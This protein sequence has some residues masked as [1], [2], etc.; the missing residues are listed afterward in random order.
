MA[1]E[2]SGGAGLLPEAG[3][4]R[5]QFLRLAA[6]AA[7]H[8]AGEAD[9]ARG[10]AA[11]ERIKELYH[12]ERDA[13][14]MS[15]DERKALRRERANPIL[16][17]FRK[18]LEAEQP[19]VLP[20]GPM[21][22]AIAYALSNW[23]ALERYTEVE[24]MGRKQRGGSANCLAT[25]LRGLKGKRRENDD[26]RNG[27][28]VAIQPLV[29]VYIWSGLRVCNV[30]L[31]PADHASEAYPPPSGGRRER[32]PSPWPLQRMFQLHPC[33]SPGRIPCESTAFAVRDQLLP[34]GCADALARQRIRQPHLRR[35]EKPPHRRPRLRDPHRA[36]AAVDKD[37]RRA[38][39][40]ELLDPLLH[41]GI[42]LAPQP[43]QLPD[44]LPR[45]HHHER[46]PARPA[47]CYVLK[48]DLAR[49]AAAKETVHARYK[50]LALVEWAFR[51]AKTVQLEMRPLYLRRAGQPHRREARALIDNPRDHPPQSELPLARGA[52]RGGYSQP[53]RDVIDDPDR[54]DRRPLPE[55]HRFGD[56]SELGEIVLVL[57]GQADGGDLLGRAVGQI[58]DRAV[59][60]LAAVAEGLAQDVARILAL[61]SAGIDVHSGYHTCGGARVTRIWPIPHK[62]SSGYPKG[63]NFAPITCPH[64]T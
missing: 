10:H 28:L 59:F 7:W 57:Q 43:G 13:K 15:P 49:K 62:H 3:R 29:K 60:D 64:T 51:T 42:A 16:A 17:E 50:D 36:R 63:A 22:G 30:R 23:A 21:G 52:E 44:D 8:E 48:T 61:S 19:K 32:A 33:G 12:V 25:A 26:A 40:R 34:R 45:E 4:R 6:E 58:R 53:A 11:L 27:F 14:E 55:A 2:R 35:G 5:A 38:Q 9:P 1:A 56:R 39:R 24:L 47:G 18:W 37:F 46:V 41:S 20:R 54:A 31:Q